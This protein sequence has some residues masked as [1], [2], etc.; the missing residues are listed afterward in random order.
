MAN[1]IGNLG[2]KL[3][4]DVGGTNIRLAT[5]TDN[6]IADIE[7]YQCI[8]FVSIQAAIE[9]YF[10]EHKDK[11]FTSACIAIAGPVNQEV[12]KFSNNDWEFT[13]SGLQNNLGLQHLFVINDFTA[14]AHSLPVLNDEQ[15]IQIG[16]GAPIV[17]STSRKLQVAGKLLMEKAVM[18]IL[19]LWMKPMSSSGVTYKPNMDERQLKRSCQDAV[20]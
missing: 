7:K 9:H 6:G 8:E 2:H 11:T 12:I 14:V 15:I 16:A 4:A 20:L 1:K 5:V 10:A 19:L 17:L 3:I 13:A 18:S